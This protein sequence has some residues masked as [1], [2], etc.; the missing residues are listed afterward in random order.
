[1]TEI[2]SLKP[3]AQLLWAEALKVPGRFG[4]SEPG[5][6]HFLLALLERHA[7]MA[8]SLA[9]G[10]SAAIYLRTIKESL[11][12]G[13]TG[14]NLDT[15]NVLKEALDLAT[16]TG[17]SEASERDLAAVLLK[18]AGF[19]L[20][21]APAW[22]GPS[23]AAQ[24]AGPQPGPQPDMQPDIQP[25]PQPE[26]ADASHGQPAA[27]RPR[28]KHPTP[29]LEQFGRDLCLQA[30]E[31]KL[32]VILGR[33]L[34]LE[35][36]MQTLCRWTKRNPLLVGPA[37]V[38]KT[39]IIEALAQRIVSGQVP[40]PLQ[41][42]RVFGLQ[43]SSLVAGASIVGQL[44]ERMREVMKEAS[45]D[46]IV[47]FIDEIHTIVGSG[48]AR[49]VSDLGSLLKP[50]LA[51]GEIAVIG[52]TTDG[53]YAGFMEQDRAL[54]RRFQPVRVQELS[55]EATLEILRKLREKAIRERGITFTDQALSLMIL[56]AQRYL[57][58]R[59]FPDKGIDL[60]EQC[61]AHA[62]LHDISEVTPS[63][64]QD[65]VER[66]VG[67]PTELGSELSER[68][69]AVTKSLFEEAFC[70]PESAAQVSQRLE[71]AM[72]GLDVEPVRPNAVLFV[73]GPAGQ[74]PELA[75]QVI[76]QSLFGSRERVIEFDLS[77]IKH[78]GDVNWLIGSA[79]GYI[80]HDNP[81]P[82]HVE[83]SQQPWSVL[84]LTNVDEC[85][86]QAHPLLAQAFHDG[87]F[88]ESHGRRIYLSDAIVLMT[89][90]LAEHRSGRP[91]GL[92][93][94]DQSQ[95]LE[96]EPA[97]PDLSRLLSPELMAEIDFAWTP[98]RPTAGRL[99]S[100][101]MQW[102]FPVLSERYLRQGLD[103]EWD[104][105]MAGWL[106]GQIVKAG[107]LL[108]GE[109]LVEDQVLPL[110]IPYLKE[111]GKVTLLCDTEGTIKVKTEK[112]DPDGV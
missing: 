108:Q 72:R 52:A 7:P 11:E 94:Q 67:M 110:L 106:A 51:K 79:P 78:E 47:L 44:E 10:L 2:S 4:H 15:D 6:N 20:V 22:K 25:V 8:E 74:V 64:V 31:G 69:T 83:L 89:A 63:L 29:K 33:D 49:Q 75:A 12:R 93:P 96:A 24:T 105:S 61:L 42:L 90:T 76:A 95:P 98:D 103:I 97:L 73:A 99:E 59:N 107:D 43:A 32:P 35:A 23:P 54:E 46:G 16:Q 28:A 14:G 18:K 104:P 56:L 36:V 87:F 53:E 84:L 86:P 38:G 27:Y 48:G 5:L 60:L 81:V 80:G 40:A 91:F 88:T 112:G 21:P 58:N 57:R 66:M 109:R 102:V 71:T 17:R 41:G 111:P 26:K 70:P 45:Q 62:L 65:V 55:G 30:L 92:V 101:L 82:F 1:M 37:G 13:D 3:G 100:W 77:R 68:L 19:Q 39:A 85:H 9:A 50:A 34:E